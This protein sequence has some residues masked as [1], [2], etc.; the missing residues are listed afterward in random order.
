MPAPD[1]QDRAGIAA[2]APD[3]GLGDKSLPAPGHR[4]PA[5]DRHDWYGCMRGAAA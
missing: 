5:P 1:E 4:A 2:G 3:S